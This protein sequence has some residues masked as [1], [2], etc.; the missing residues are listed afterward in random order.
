MKRSL[1]FRLWRSS[2]HFVE[3]DNSGSSESQ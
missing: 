3:T 2:S 1:D